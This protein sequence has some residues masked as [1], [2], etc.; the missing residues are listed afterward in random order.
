MSCDGHHRKLYLLLLGLSMLFGCFMATD[1]VAAQPAIQGN[2]PSR[3]VTD[4]IQELDYLNSGQSSS[5]LVHF[6]CRTLAYCSQCAQKSTSGW[7]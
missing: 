4:L 1:A 7:H 3:I 2:A 6:L 5:Q